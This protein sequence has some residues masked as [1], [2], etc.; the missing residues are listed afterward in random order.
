M[1]ETGNNQSVN[2][3]QRLVVRVSQG[4]LAFAV[5]D[6]SAKGQLLF[7]PY[8]MKS[9]ISVAANLRDAFTSSVLLQ[10][11]YQ[12]ALVMT[13]AKPM[14]LPVDEYADDDVATL[15]EYAFTKKE[16]EMLVHTVLP[17]LNT[18]AVFAFNKDLH[19]VFADHFS[20]LRV[21]P[22]MLPVWTYLHRRS[23]SGAGRKLYA[24]FHENV[25]EVFCFLQ[26]RFRFYNRFEVGNPHDAVFF[27]LYVWKQLSFQVRHD[28][29]CLS[30]NI[31]D[32]DELMRLLQ[33]YVP[34]VQ[35]IHAS[36]EF[37]RAPVTQVKGITFDL[38]T[39]FVK[40]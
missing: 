28:A 3:H 21:E 18:V 4:T 38:I 37:L 16:N 15:Y 27:L 8:V 13:D 2:I 26:N 40:S 1:Q 11:G 29:L 24:Y 39:R 30:G 23:F 19:Q 9:G 10:R 25:L 12:R 7:E 17:D 22:L 34:N 33:R 6:P 5:P 32:E 35:R 36:A 20:D 31:P 14:M